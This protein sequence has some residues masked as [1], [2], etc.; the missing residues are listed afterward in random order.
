LMLEI[1]RRGPARTPSLRQIEDADAVLV[2]GEDL[3]NVAPRMA[4]SVRQSVRRPAAAAAERLHIP[5]WMDQAVRETAQDVK[6]PLFIAWVGATRL[7]DVATGTFRGAP[8]DLARLGFSV[9]SMIRGN[10]PGISGDAGAREIAEAFERAN[11]GVVIAGPTLRSPALIQAAANLAWAKPGLALAFVTPEYNSFGLAM[12]DAP[13]LDAVPEAETA[14]ILENDLFRRLPEDEVDRLLARFRQVVAVDSVETATTARAELVLPAAT[15]AEGSGTFV[16]SEGRAQRAFRAF[17]PGEPI[18]ESWRWLSDW[19]NLDEAIAETA[20]VLAQFEGI[21]RAAP[22]ANYRMAGQ[23][24]P[25]EPQRYSGRTAML[26]QITVQ[27]PKP[28]DDPDSPLSFSMEGNPDQPPS[29][30]IPFFW[31]PGWNSIQAVNRYQAEIGAALRRGEAGV[32]LI[33]PD[34]AGAAYFDE[35]PA[36]FAVQPGEWLLVPMP[37]IFGSEELSRLSPP[38]A[39][40]APAPYLALNR[41][42]AAQFGREAKCL[43]HRVPVQLAAE[44]P[45]GIAGVPM[46]IAPFAGLELPMWAKIASVS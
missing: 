14:I 33:E 28:P 7:D 23:K 25:R 3:T 45:D 31:S 15:F 27:E 46:G 37:H 11:H 24:I 44:L 19:G 9:A 12:M 30:L 6:G 4:L 17:A 29:A 10:A 20:L 34:A 5:V 18:Q 8:D 1:L 36:P 2:L 13:A 40:L 39:Q 22:P 26:A 42:G 41:A 21:A 43:G 38:I 16:S 35:I 32:R